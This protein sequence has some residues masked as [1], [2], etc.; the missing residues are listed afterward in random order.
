MVSAALVPLQAGSWLISIL[1]GVGAVPANLTV[2]FTV[3]TVFGSTGVAGAAG[4]L[5]VAAFSS[6]AF[7]D[8]SSFLLQAARNNSARRAQVKITV[9]FFLFITWSTTLG[10]GKRFLELTFKWS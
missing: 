7:E 10:F 3:A 8:C 9:Q 4:A 1:A 2:P 6:D 5:E